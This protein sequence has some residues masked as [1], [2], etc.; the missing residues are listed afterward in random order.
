[1][2]YKRITILLALFAATG[3]A[4]A[5][6]WATPPDS[7]Q[8]LSSYQDQALLRQAWSLPV[9]RRYG[10][11]G[12]VYQSD[13]SV[14]GPTSIADVLRSEGRPLNPQVVMRGTHFLTVFG[15]LPGGLT[16][17]QEASILRLRSGEPVTVLR[18]L[19]LAQ[20]RSEI[21]HSNDQSRRYIVNFARAALFGRGHGHFSPVLGY[22]IK[23]D[24]VFVGDVNAD[25][26]PWLVPTARLYSAQ[27]SIDPESGA[28]RGL[29]WVKAQ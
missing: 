6:F 25:F 28:K 7:I 21:A 26:G 1:L 4:G 11:F 14:C 19:S 20:F 24:L 22:L 16:L 27:D 13:A 2:G 17:D 15:Y 8:R 5:W 18:G 12:Y 10:P 9:A 3:I 23:N 29:L